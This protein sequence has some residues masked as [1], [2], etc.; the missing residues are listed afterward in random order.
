[1]AIPALLAAIPSIIKAG[2]MIIDRVVP[3]KNAAEKAKQEL[4][5]AAQNNDFT[6]ALKQI[7]VNLEEAKSTNWFVAGWR[8]FVGWTCGWA[9]AYTFVIKPFL[10]FFVFTFGTPEMVKQLA[11][12]PSLDLTTLLPVL[13]GMLGLGTLRTIEKA[14]KVEDER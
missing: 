14:K 4:R 7:L 11:M 1:M 5:V 8:P 12:L 3:D 6:L 10:M 2:E 9:F 13:F